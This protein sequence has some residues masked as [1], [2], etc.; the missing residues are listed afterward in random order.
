MSSQIITPP[1]KVLSKQSYL[2]INAIDT[3]IDTLVLWL[4]TISEQYDIH[5]WHS[6]MI[7]SELWLYHV[8]SGVEHVLVNKKFENYLPPNLRRILD[9]KSN[10]S[11]FGPDTVNLELIH[12]FLRNRTN[13]N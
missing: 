8:I 11:Y 7:D 10:L 9:R 6:Q 5:L 3:E 1:D 4:K 2:V 13:N 12:W